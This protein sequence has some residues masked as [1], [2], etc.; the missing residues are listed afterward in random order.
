[1]LCFTINSHLL[2]HDFKKAVYHQ[3]CNVCKI[4]FRLNSYKRMRFIRK[5][6]FS[7]LN[8]FSKVLK[9]FLQPQSLVK[10]LFLPYSSH[11]Y[12]YEL[13]RGK[14]R[15]RWLSV[16]QILLK[17]FTLTHKLFIKLK[18]TYVSMDQIL[19]S[20][21]KIDFEIIKN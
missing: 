12:K 5:L 20:K 6:I 4:L 21:N 11:L 16:S 9:Y 15:Y 18:S 14:A 10:L 13:K 1:M 7:N 17:Q 2:C 19:I 3:F 8:I